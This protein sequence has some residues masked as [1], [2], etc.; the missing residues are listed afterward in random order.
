[1]FF[2]LF[3]KIGINYPRAV[4]SPKL[5]GF[6]VL[7]TATMKGG[8]RWLRKRWLGHSTSFFAILYQ[9]KANCAM[10]SEADF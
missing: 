7:F 4:I 6:T 5:L 1:M 10:N 9:H 8:R 3:V 2:F